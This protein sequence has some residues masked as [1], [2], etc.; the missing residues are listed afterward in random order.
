MVEN[1]TS[2]TWCYQ[3]ALEVPSNFLIPMWK[4]PYLSL[5]VFWWVHVSVNG[6]LRPLWCRVSSAPVSTSSACPPELA[7][8]VSWPEYEFLHPSSLWWGC[9]AL[10]HIKHI[11]LLMRSSFKIITENQQLYEELFFCYNTSIASKDDITLHVVCT[12]SKS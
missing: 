2:K 10:Q 4:L 11:K 3:H 7:A 1:W 8:S 6:D 12:K 5:V 9:Q